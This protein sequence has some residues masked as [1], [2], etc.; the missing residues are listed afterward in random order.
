LFRAIP[1]RLR[2]DPAVLTFMKRFLIP[3]FFTIAVAQAQVTA[4]WDGGTSTWDD[5]THWSTNPNFPNNG[6]PEGT[7]YNAVINAG[8]VTHSTA[9]AIERLTLS[10]GRLAFGG[11]DP[12]TVAAGFDWSGA[13]F[14]LKPFPIRASL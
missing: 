1:D 5:S 4:I 12:L 6:T 13:N 10:G 2:N 9:T 11:G 3:W 14:T 8:E 7:T